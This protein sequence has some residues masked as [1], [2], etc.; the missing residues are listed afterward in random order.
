MRALLFFGDHHKENVMD[1]KDTIKNNPKTAAGVGV[2][3]VFAAIAAFVKF[4]KKEEM[5]AIFSE[6]IR[7]E[8]LEFIKLV[9]AVSPEIVVKGDKKTEKFYSLKNMPDIGDHK[10]ILAF[11]ATK[12]EKDSLADKFFVEMS[13]VVGMIVTSKTGIHYCG[14]DMDNYKASI[15]KMRELIKKMAKEEKHES[16]FFSKL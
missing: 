13:F 12:T 10:E 5:V 7:A 2:G 9:E 4:R 6:D 14:V 15:K 3:V 1:I 8:L 11:M 16:G